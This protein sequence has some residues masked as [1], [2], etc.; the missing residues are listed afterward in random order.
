MSVYWSLGGE[1]WVESTLTSGSILKLLLVVA[2]GNFPI[3][4]VM[5]PQESGT[6]ASR[7]L[8]KKL[9]QKT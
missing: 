1:E 4:V 6:G 7:S 5:I 2:D 8:S 3:F 9:T